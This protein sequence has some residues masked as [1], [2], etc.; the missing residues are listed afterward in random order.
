M[1]IAKNPG[2]HVSAEAPI[3]LFRNSA[4]DN[5]KSSRRDLPE[6]LLVVVLAPGQG[7]VPWL[8][9]GLLMAMLP[10]AIPPQKCCLWVCF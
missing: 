10:P 5:P 2:K 8:L 6:D 1:A 7:Q 4:L 3:G 9:D